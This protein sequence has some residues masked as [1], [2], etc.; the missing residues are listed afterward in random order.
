MNDTEILVR[1]DQDPPLYQPGATLSGRL[2]VRVPPDRELDAVE[3]S[4]LWY[5]EGKGDEDLGVHYFERLS[6]QDGTLLAP[7]EVRP[8]ATPLP[9]SPLSY[10]G[11]ILKIRW[12][13][14]VRAFLTNRAT[15]L[16]EVPFQLGDVPPAREVLP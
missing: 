12:C 2:E 9:P 13:V 1:L 10:D 8:F 3:V 16:E 6:R 4:V 7:G 15:P 11:V 14:R 5:T